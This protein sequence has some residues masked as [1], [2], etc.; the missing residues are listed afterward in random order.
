MTRSHNFAGGLIILID[1]DHRAANK[2]DFRV[3]LKRFDLNIERAWHPQVIIVQERD[4]L[5]AAREDTKVARASD[6]LISFYAKVLYTGQVSADFGRLVGGS[7]VNDYDF[8]IRARGVR[9]LDRA[10]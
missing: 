6:A 9:A 1:H 7:I 8:D 5:S 3:G 4:V 2:A 10:R